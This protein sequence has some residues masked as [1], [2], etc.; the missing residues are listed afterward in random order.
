MI[1]INILLEIDNINR[2]R[3]LSS[4]KNISDEKIDSFS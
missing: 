2:G 4:I 1:I 3:N